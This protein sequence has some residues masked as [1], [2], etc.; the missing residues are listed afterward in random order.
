MKGKTSPA[1]SVGKVAKAGECCGCS[2]TLSASGWLLSCR[3]EGRSRS[4]VLRELPACSAFCSQP[5]PAA[6]ERRRLPRPEQRAEGR[7]RCGGTGDVGSPEQNFLLPSSCQSSY[8]S[9][10]AENSSSYGSP[11]GRKLGICCPT[12]KVNKK[13]AF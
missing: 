4:F 3:G 6:R 10:Q 8:S 12:S 9:Q 13:A 2:Q 5:T 11:R 1:Q 7:A